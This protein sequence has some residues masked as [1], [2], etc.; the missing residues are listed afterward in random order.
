MTAHVEEH[1]RKDDLRYTLQRM[2]DVNLHGLSALIMCGTTDI[3]RQAMVYMVGRLSVEELRCWEEAALSRS[4]Q[5]PFSALVAGASAFDTN[6]TRGA[7]SSSAHR[8]LHSLSAVLSDF[9]VP[10]EETVELEMTGAFQDDWYAPIQGDGKDP[11]EVSNGRWLAKEQEMRMKD[12]QLGQTSRQ[13]DFER[14]RTEW[15]WSECSW[16]EIREGRVNE[17]AVE[18]AN[19]DS[20]LQEAYSE[21]WGAYN[22]P[23]D[24]EEEVVTDQASMPPRCYRAVNTFMGEDEQV[25]S[26]Y[27]SNS[28]SF[29]HVEADLMR[30]CCEQMQSQ[31]EKDQTVLG[32]GDRAEYNNELTNVFHD[33]RMGFESARLDAC[34]NSDGEFK[35]LT[36]HHDQVRRRQLQHMIYTTEDENAPGEDGGFDE[37]QAG[38]SDVAHEGGDNARAADPQESSSTGRPQSTEPV[39]PEAEKDPETT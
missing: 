34:K 38:D 21:E 36:T 23:P 16:R 18:E 1:D 31:C 37:A 32:P 10:E 17:I 2:D 33:L 20:E 39:E 26:S 19:P 25:Q 3:L 9:A 30:D 5:N 28:Q 27:I 14:H 6:N 4:G 12:F 7:A 29:W 15:L 8:F 35:E 22:Q 11:V 24:Y 13:L